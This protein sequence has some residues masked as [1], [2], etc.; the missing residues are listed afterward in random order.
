M[1]RLHGGEE[2]GGGGRKKGEE[3]G[4]V[5]REEEG[6]RRGGGEARRGGEGGRGKMKGLYK[7]VQPHCGAKKGEIH[8]HEV[9][10]F[11][12]TAL[13]AY[14]GSALIHSLPTSK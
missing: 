6:R 4:E 2:G 10:K 14:R 5:Q 9:L 13:Y 3:G 12:K 1:C 8:L 11:L 7:L